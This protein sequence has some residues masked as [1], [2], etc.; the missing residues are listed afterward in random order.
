M[1]Q[2]EYGPKTGLCLTQDPDGR[3]KLLTFRGE[4]GPKSARGMAYSAADIVVPEYAKLDRLVLDGGFPH[5]L[6]VAMGDITEDVRM[7]CKFLGVE[8]VSPHD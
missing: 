4:S 7:L 2:F 5:H 8:Y 3:F 1:G 6:A